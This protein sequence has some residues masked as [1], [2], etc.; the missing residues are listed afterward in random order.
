MATTT[1]PSIKTQLAAALERIAELEA[2]QAVA[3]AAQPAAPQREAGKA[4]RYQLGT[5]SFSR[6]ILA[7]VSV[8]AY[9]PRD[10][11]QVKQAMAWAF[12]LRR[13]FIAAGHKVVAI[14]APEYL[15]VTGW[16]PEHADTFEYFYGRG[17][18]YIAIY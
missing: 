10:G 5:K 11:D 13:Q 2:A 17:Q 3:Q 9:D 15:G 12:E 16:V 1:K 18:R 6:D 14:S 4:A 7:V 8:D